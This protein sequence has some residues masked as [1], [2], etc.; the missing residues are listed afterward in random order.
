MV[1]FFDAL[2]ERRSSFG[3]L[4]REAASRAGGSVGVKL[5][6]GRIVGTD[7]SGAAGPID[8]PSGA[9]TRPIPGGGE[10]WLLRHE[11]V[12]NPT[13]G[14]FLRRLAL[15]ALGLAKLRYAND[16]A[17]STADALLD[18]VD[19]ASTA[20][21]RAVALERVGVSA[22]APIRLVA[23]KGPEAPCEA[24]AAQVAR[25]TRVRASA[26]TR[27]LW[28]ALVDATPDPGVIQ[29]LPEG[30]RAVRTGARPADQTHRALAEAQ[31]SM[32][33]ALPSPRP[34]GPYLFGE[35][36]FPSS[37]EIGS[38]M[39]LATLDRAVFDE[40]DDLRALERLIAETDERVLRILRAYS[41]TASM[42]KAAELTFVHHNSVAHWVR[43]AEAALGFDLNAPYGRSRLL[44]ALMLHRLK[45][46]DDEP[47]G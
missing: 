29:D 8:R 36:V 14:F 28:L 35:A 40:I 6:G 31:A 10:V 34:Q 45:H 7:P 13:D 30:V 39:V 12:E 25:R 33:F 22:Q 23:W 37:D 2:V 5:P 11:G 1:D 15:A 44:F 18:L 3:E 21:E 16:N 46:N 27:D 41:A 19:I 42:R 47:G 38:F 43:R 17:F 26:T 32:R 4:V 20:E 24:F 9:S